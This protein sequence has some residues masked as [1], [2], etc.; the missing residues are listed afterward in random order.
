MSQTVRRFFSKIKD[1]GI[2]EIWVCRNYH[3]SEALKFKVN[4][5]HQIGKVEPNNFLIKDIGTAKI[6]SVPSVIIQIILYRAIVEHV[7]VI[8]GPL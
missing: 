6:Y 5:E 8:K 2:Y 3:K 4:F 1:S 7:I